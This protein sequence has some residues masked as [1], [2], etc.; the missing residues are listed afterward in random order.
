MALVT[1][2]T[3]ASVQEIDPEMVTEADDDLGVSRISMTMTM[4]VTLK[5]RQSMTETATRM[6]T[7][8]LEAMEVVQVL[9]MFKS[10]S[11]KSSYQRLTGSDLNLKLIK[12]S[13][14]LTRDQYRSMAQP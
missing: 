12:H 1:C 8:P 4:V 10:S 13:S 14:P 6:A 7:L 5:A 11:C 9:R 2:I 3:V